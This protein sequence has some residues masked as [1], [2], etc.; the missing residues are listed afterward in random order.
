MN[1]IPS[2]RLNMES[3]LLYAMS[4]PKKSPTLEAMVD[5]I[6]ETV[7]CCPPPGFTKV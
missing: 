6:L 4:F 7:L 3:I 1:Y 2:K 5:R